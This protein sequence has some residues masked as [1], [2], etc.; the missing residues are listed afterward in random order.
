LD[1]LRRILAGV[2]LVQRRADPAEVHR[3]RIGDFDD[4]AAAKVDAQVQAAGGQEEDG[5]QECHER[6]HVE[7]E[8]VPHE[9]DVARDSEKFHR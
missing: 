7:R 2:E 8:R 9:R 4:G 5:Q 6:D 3:M 1:S